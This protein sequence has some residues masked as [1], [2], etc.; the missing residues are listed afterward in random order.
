MEQ[1]LCARGYSDQ[2]AGF[3]SSSLLLSG[4]VA[5]FP[6]SV[7][8][9]KLN[10]SLQI[11]KMILVT[12]VIF[13]GGLAYLLIIPEHATLLIILSIITGMLGIR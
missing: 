13:C 1:L 10:K 7:I 11:S 4:C 5:S 6:A 8:I 3:A 2:I 12:A 9:A